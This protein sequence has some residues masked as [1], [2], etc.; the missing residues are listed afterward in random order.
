MQTIVTKGQVSAVKQDDLE[1]PTYMR[2]LM[3]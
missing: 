3:D 2:R 1:I